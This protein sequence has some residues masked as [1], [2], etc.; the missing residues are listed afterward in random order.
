M[1]STCDICRFSKRKSK[2]EKYKFPNK[3][4]SCGSSVEKEYNYQTKKFDAVIRCSS[5]GFEC[6]KISIEKISILYQK[7]H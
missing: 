4:P 7:M 5:E 3:C 6:E 2:L 1:L